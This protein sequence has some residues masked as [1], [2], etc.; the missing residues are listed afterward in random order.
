M[1][2]FWCWRVALVAKGLYAKGLTKYMATKL[3]TENHDMIYRWWFN[4]QPQ[5]IID[6]IY[7]NYTAKL[8]ES[9]ISIFRYA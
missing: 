3:A 9:E 5:D 7:E 8:L 2:E 1:R 6:R 4:Y